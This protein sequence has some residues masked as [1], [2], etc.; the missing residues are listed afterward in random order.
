MERLFL[1]GPGRFSLALSQA[2]LARDAVDRIQICGRHADPPA[3]PLFGHARVEYVYGLSRPAPDTTAVFLGVPDADLAE[4]AWALGGQGSPGAPVPAFHASAAMSTEVLAPLH[5]QGYTVGCFHPMVALDRSLAAADRL[6]GAPVLLTGER[7]AAAAGR[8]IVQVLGGRVV[9]V[10][11]TRRAS[12]SAAESLVIEGGNALL[13]IGR[14]IFVE[15]GLP[16][17]DAELVARA[18][19]RTLATGPGD[20][21]AAPGV[22]RADEEVDLHLRALPPE[23]ADLYRRLLESGRTQ[24]LER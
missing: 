10:P 13:E 20:P 9:E 23:L 24:E 14:R 2:L 11:V 3:H 17:H 15:A 22:D 21:T 8:R 16:D 1:V 12:A 6:V 5:G 18:L 19:L 7:G 4:M